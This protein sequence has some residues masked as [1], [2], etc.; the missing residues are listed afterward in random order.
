M[1]QPG[2]FFM[3]S[4]AQYDLVPLRTHAAL[5]R[6]LLDELDRI[7]PASGTT[8]HDATSFVIGEE[9]G[10]LGCQLLECAASLAKAH[11][12]RPAAGQA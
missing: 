6:S 10:R 7:V 8:P 9:L 4:A 11:I 5:T 1:V 2:R 3:A 12:P